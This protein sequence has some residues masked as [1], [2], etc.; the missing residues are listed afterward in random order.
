MLLES[1][2]LEERDGAYVLAGP[3]PDASVPTRLQDLLRARLDRM[4]PEARMVM[5]LGSAVGRE[6][7]YELLVDVLPDESVTIRKGLQQLLDAGLVFATGSGFMIKHELIKDEG[8]SNR[9]RHF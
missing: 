6:F 7:A 1:G 3:M 2:W 9:R 5:Q 8:T 4:E